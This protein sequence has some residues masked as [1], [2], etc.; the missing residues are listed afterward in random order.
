M[1]SFDTVSEV[2]LQ[3][4]S[5]AVDQANR[6]VGNRYDFKGSCA[7]VE[8]SDNQLSLQA[9]NEFQLGQVKDILYKKL[10][11]RGI[12]LGSLD[13]GRLE[14]RN[15]QARRVLAVQQGIPQ[16]IARKIVK[17]VKDSKLKVQI[18]IQSDKVRVTGKKRDDLQNVIAFLKEAPIDLPLQYI[19]FRD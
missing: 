12:N 7:K 11:K 3:E 4:V 1:P 2:D 14:T 13:E 9:D 19:N 16:D 17:L 6:E 5:N 10:A 18:S 8:Q 15:N